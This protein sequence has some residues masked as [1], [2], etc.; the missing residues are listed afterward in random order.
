MA[1]S[2]VW[3]FSSQTFASK[4][5]VDIP[6]DSCAKNESGFSTKV[7]L[8]IQK[9]LACSMLSAREG[10][11]HGMDQKLIGELKVIVA[12]GSASSPRALLALRT[13]TTLKTR[14]GHFCM[15]TMFSA[16]L[17]HQLR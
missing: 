16:S 15:C 7:L 6:G 4:L 1:T 5:T 10:L 11:Y 2:P 14:G 13:S 9:F 12:N 17:H 8:D 3:S